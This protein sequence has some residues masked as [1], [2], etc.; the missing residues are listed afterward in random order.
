[1]LE[2]KVIQERLGHASVASLTLDIYTHTE[3][4]E[5]VEAATPAGEQIEKAANSVSLTAVKEEWLAEENQQT[6]VYV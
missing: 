6:L 5:N 4:Q 2:V 1:M 3:W